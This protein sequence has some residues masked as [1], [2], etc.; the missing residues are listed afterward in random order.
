MIGC[1]LMRILVHE[2]SHAIVV[3]ALGGTVT[4]FIIGTSAG[5]PRIFINFEMLSIANQVWVGLAGGTGAGI[6]FICMTKRYPEAAAVAVMSF[7]Y[8]FGEAH[9]SI[10][11]VDASVVLSFLYM[12]SMGGDIFISQLILYRFYSV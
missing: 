6:V 12:V 10:P 11:S 5:V 9:L 2:G 3:L 1:Y 7:I 4:G 8:A